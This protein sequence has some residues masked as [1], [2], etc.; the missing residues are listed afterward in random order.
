MS[1]ED[2][3]GEAKHELKEESKES[4]QTTK[5][6]TPAT[7]SS[8]SSVLSTSSSSFDSEALA[9]PPPPQSTG[10]EQT[11]NKMPWLMRKFSFRADDKLSSNGEKPVSFVR[12]NL[13]KFESLFNSTNDALKTQ[14]VVKPAET[15]ASPMTLIAENVGSNSGAAKTMREEATDAL[16][17]LKTNNQIPRSG[18]NR[19]QSYTHKTQLNETSSWISRHKNSF[20]FIKPATVKRKHYIINILLI[21]F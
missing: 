12:Y 2:L 20:Y 9:T 17:E 8:T 1:E 15:G 7:L 21:F 13:R 18:I 5:S 3:V 4:T 19:S 11:A 16:S 6:S 10:P 14:S